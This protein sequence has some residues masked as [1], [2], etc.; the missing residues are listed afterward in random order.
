MFI[1]IGIT[2]VNLD[3][4]LKYVPMDKISISSNTIFFIRFYYDLKTYVDKI[5]NTKQE[6]DNFL[7]DIDNIKLKK[8]N[9][10]LLKS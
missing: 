5:F 9:P 3:S 4:F 10:T 6:R 1:N 8:E 2:R 7:N